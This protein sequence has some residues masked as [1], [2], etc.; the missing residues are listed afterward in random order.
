MK[1]IKILFLVVAL[2]AYLPSAFSQGVTTS[3]MRGKV[4]DPQNSPIFAATVVATHTPTGTQY[5]TI[6]QD[7]GRFDI[8]NM[9]IGGPYTVTV[10]FI[11]YK[12]SKQE[13]IYLQLNKSAEINLVIH[14]DN[15]QID[16]ITVI[17]DKNDVISQDRTGAQTNLNRERI[18]SLPTISRISRI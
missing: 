9:K 12:E 17:Y 11:G 3:S 10:T 14:E 15:V 7:D 13:N 2:V 1:K 4:V 16:E 6:T 8:R 5:G 18:I